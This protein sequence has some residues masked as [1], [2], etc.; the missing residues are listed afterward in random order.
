MI[1]ALPQVAIGGG[2]KTIRWASLRRRLRRAWRAGGRRLRLVRGRFRGARYAALGRQPKAGVADAVLVAR[3]RSRLGPLG[4][5]LDLPRIRV[6][7]CDGVAVL[8]GSVGT[9]ED[10]ELLAAA[11]ADVPGVRR[12]SSHLH[13]GL[14]REETRPS[15]SRVVLHRLRHRRSRPRGGAGSC[16]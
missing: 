14:G 2:R 12:I 16:R 10:A 15:T 7:V 11:T 6:M 5:R 3:V 8:H 1:L 13:V 4:K 9:V